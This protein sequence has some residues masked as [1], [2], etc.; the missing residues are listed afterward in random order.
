MSIIR[1]QSLFDIHELYEMEPT[2]HFEA[3]FST[4]NL[5]PILNLFDKPNKVGAPR[6]LNYGAMIYSLIA[7]VVER[8]VTIKD[9]IR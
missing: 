9:L 6:E 8:I 7:R 2:H 4:I 1:Q 3:V 5:D